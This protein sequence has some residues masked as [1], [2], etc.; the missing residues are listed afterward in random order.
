MAFPF[1]SNFA[2]KTSVPLFAMAAAVFTQVAPPSVV[3]CKF[4]SSVPTQ[5]KFSS[6]E[7]SAKV[8]MVQ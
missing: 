4:P 6:N 1:G 2:T 3:Y 8:K 7:D 5:I